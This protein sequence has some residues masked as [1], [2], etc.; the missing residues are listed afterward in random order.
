MHHES[1]SSL[2]RLEKHSLY[3]LNLTKSLGLGG[4]QDQ[5]RERGL[6]GPSS[7]S[8]PPVRKDQRLAGNT[9]FKETLVCHFSAV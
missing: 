4:C 9:V 3:K 7:P 1:H 2:S 8:H 6:F 5:R